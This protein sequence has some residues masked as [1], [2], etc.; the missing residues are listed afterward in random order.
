MASALSIRI[1]SRVQRLAGEIPQARFMADM[2]F[3]ITPP[4]KFWHYLMLPV[5]IPVIVTVLVLTN[6]A[7]L[8]FAFVEIFGVRG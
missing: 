2:T 8:A 7:L 1:T 4:K 5:S 6:V 3:H